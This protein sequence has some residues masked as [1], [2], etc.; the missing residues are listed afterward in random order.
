MPNRPFRFV[1]TLQNCH[2]DQRAGAFCRPVGGETPGTHIKF[3]PT[4]FV[5]N[6]FV[7]KYKVARAANRA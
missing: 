5:P 6:A 7:R 1:A 2:F 4:H 3:S